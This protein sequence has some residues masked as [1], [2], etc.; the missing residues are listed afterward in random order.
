MNLKIDFNFVCF[1][2]VSIIKNIFNL[3]NFSMHKLLY[4]NKIKKKE[5]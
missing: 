4:L 5:N 1:I 3:D 2:E